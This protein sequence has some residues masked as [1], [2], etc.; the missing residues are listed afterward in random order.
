MNWNYRVVRK[1]SD[2]DEIDYGIHEIYYSDSGS[3]VLFTSEPLVVA[4]TLDE[5][6]TKAGWMVGALDEAVID[7]DV[8][9]DSLEEI[10]HI[11]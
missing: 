10:P 7:Y 1:S 2:G 4:A 5:L 3:V 6:T 11:G 9:S 8:L